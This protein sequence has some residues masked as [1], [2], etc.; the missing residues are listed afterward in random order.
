MRPLFN[1][2]VVVTAS[3]LVSAG[4]QAAQYARINTDD[5]VVWVERKG[6]ILHHLSDSPLAGGEI[7]ANST[8]VNKAEFVLPVES[9]TVF[10]VG[11]NYRSHAGNAGASKP[12][13]FYKSASSLS[14]GGEL[15][16]PADANNVHFEGELVVVIGKPCAKVTK[17]QASNCIFAY[18]AG[19]DLTERS[20][21]GQDLQWWRAKGANGFA[22]ISP[23]LTTVSGENTFTVTT[24]LND[25]VVQQE[26]SSNMIHSVEDIVS[27]I[28]Q[29]LTLQPWDVI[30]T[31]TPGRTQALKSGD[32]VSVSIEG[33]GEVLTHIK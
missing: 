3:L 1:G 19:N 32:K 4:L 16:L 25:K 29:Y 10:A 24:T 26:S 18:T 2:L 15:E 5:G 9:A 21:Q 20:W 6:E 27:Y 28:S 33:L 22:P 30:F 17:Q 31:G 13:I 23:W 7:K 14:I 11:L 8:P 12:E